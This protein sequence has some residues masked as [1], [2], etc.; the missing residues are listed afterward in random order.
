MN[1]DDDDGHNTIEPDNDALILWRVDPTGQFWRLDASAVGR[2]AINVESELLERV[3]RWRTKQTYQHGEESGE[4]HCDDA[5]LHEDVRSYL[6]SLSPDE[7]VEVATECLVNG[8]M[9]NIRKQQQHAN[10]NDDSKTMIQ[11][12]EQGL[13]KRV[14]A[15]VIRS[16]GFGQSKPRIAIA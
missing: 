11:L 4:Q 7:A 16:N 14:Q 6:G 10:S 2:G 15:V 5:L 8:I 3:Q 13:R 9:K 12:L 1:R